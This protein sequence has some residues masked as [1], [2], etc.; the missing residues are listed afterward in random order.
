MK[1]AGVIGSAPRP[2]SSRDPSPGGVFGGSLGGRLPSIGSSGLKWAGVD[3]IARRHRPL[4]DHNR[5][6]R[7][8]SA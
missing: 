4:P 2:H 3:N 8:C 6:R 7:Q 1:S 5:A